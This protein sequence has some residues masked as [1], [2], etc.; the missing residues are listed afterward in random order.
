MQSP[1]LSSVGIGTTATTLDCGIGMVTTP[2]LTR[3]VTSGVAFNLV[4]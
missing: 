1:S 3:T 2:C 4:I